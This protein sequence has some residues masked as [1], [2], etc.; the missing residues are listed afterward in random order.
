MK[1]I[2]ASTPG[3]ASPWRGR[4]GRARAAPAAG[5]AVAPAA[6]AVRSS[7]A[8]NGP[9][10]RPSIG[11][12]APAVPAAAARPGGIEAGHARQLQGARPRSPGPAGRLR[13]QPRGAGGVASRRRRGGCLG[14][15]GG[16]E[17]GGHAQQH[18]RCS[19]PRS[20][21]AS[22]RAAAIGR[23]AGARAGWPP[24][25]WNS[26]A[27]AAETLRLRP[28][29]CRPGHPGLAGLEH[30]GGRPLFLIAEHQGEGRLR[31]RSSGGTP[32][33]ATAAATR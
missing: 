6:P 24:S 29:R 2:C 8:C 33:A 14:H 32:P 19:P 1:L 27:A 5:P 23:G 20:G 28:G 15:G 9:A 21:A 4:S 17:G 3:R 11:S 31:G 13:P 16:G 26:T 22:R 12:P 7:T 25:A 10:G 18:G 30:R